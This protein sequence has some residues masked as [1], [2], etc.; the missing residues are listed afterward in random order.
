R[1]RRDLV[2]SFRTNCGCFSKVA[3][4]YEI[5]TCMFMWHLD[6][7]PRN[8]RLEIQRSRL[9]F[10]CPV[11]RLFVQVRSKSDKE[12]RVNV[13]SPARQ[14]HI[15]T[16]QKNCESQRWPTPKSAVAWHPLELAPCPASDCLC[17]RPCRPPARPA[18]PLPGRRPCP[19]QQ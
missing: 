13:T 8:R 17:H 18:F 10:T 7:K 2:S 1:E 14:C 16:Y 9:E 6:V 15:S 12:C 19:D 3:S 4:V 11:Y 5:S